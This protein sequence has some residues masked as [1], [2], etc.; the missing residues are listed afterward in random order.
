MLRVFFDTFLQAPD[1][2]FLRIRYFLFGIRRSDHG[3]PIFIPVKEDPS[4]NLFRNRGKLRA[5]LFRRH[6][7]FF[8]AYGHQNDRVIPCGDVNAEVIGHRQDLFQ[9]T[10]IGHKRAEQQILLR[11]FLFPCKLLAPGIILR[12]RSLLLDFLLNTPDAFQ[13][14]PRR[15]RL[16]QIIGDAQRDGLL[17]I[18][19][20]IISGKNDNRGI[21]KFL[22]DKRRQLQPIHKR[23]LDIGQ[24]DI[25]LRLQNHR[26][27]K[28]P[29]AG[30]PDKLDIFLFPVDLP[31]DAVAHYNLVLNKE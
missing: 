16:K 24:Q 2:L 29:V 21:R 5:K 11:V 6:R 14:L 31:L 8:S 20:L 22:P 18:D 30:L 23:H 12:L 7:I 25:R 15:K 19:K 28:F 1:Q 3:K 26:P 10:V 17:G 9:R 13:K 4:R 27:C